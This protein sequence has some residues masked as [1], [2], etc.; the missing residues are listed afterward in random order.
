MKRW[1]AGALLL[2]M[3]ICLG[4][5]REAGLP[6]AET[7]DYEVTA[8]GRVYTTKG[9]PFVFIPTVEARGYLDYRTNE[10]GTVGE[11]L[12]GTFPEGT[13]VYGLQGGNNKTMLLAV[14]PETQHCYLVTSYDSLT[15]TAGRTVTEAI[16][17]HNNIAYVYRYNAKKTRLIPLV[18][19]TLELSDLG[20]AYGEGT[21]IQPEGKSVELVLESFNGDMGTFVLYENGAIVFD[22]CPQYAIDL[23]AEMN[24][25]LWSRLS[26]KNR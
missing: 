21:L 2:I 25:L 12:T 1:I 23:G 3:M 16:D 19:D 20:T 22:G 18:L 8:N 5:C 7:G 24:A 6:V 10:V 4:G 26:T 11:E 14:L 17:F 15:V 9:T 13:T